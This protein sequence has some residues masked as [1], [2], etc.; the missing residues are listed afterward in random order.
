MLLPSEKAPGQ[1]M[2]ALRSLQTLA[3]RNADLKN[4][5]QTWRAPCTASISYHS[6]VKV[7]LCL[8]S[9]QYWD[10]GGGKARPAGQQLLN[11]DWR[12]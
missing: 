5:Q 1:R 2:L 8:A 9:L 6:H 3:S 10:A 11:N 4:H 7:R 12:R